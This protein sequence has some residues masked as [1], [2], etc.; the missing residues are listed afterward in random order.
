MVVYSR[1]AL[2]QNVCSAGDPNFHFLRARTLICCQDG[3]GCDE[4]QICLG[5]WSDFD[6]TMS[7]FLA[8]FR[9]WM[10]LGIL[11]WKMLFNF[12][13]SIGGP[14]RRYIKYELLI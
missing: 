7:T 11:E 4:F 6:H 14:G 13:K 8:F 9:N 10:I 2:V 12:G 5:D 1:G 3:V